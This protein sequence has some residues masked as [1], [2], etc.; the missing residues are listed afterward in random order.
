[1]ARDPARTGGTSLPVRCVALILCVGGACASARTGEVESDDGAVRDAGGSVDAPFSPIDAAIDGA[2]A[3]VGPP[4]CDEPVGETCAGIDG[5]V[6]VR[7]AVPGELS[8]Y[9]RLYPHGD[10]Y[11]FTWIEGWLEPVAHVARLDACGAL[12]GPVHDFPDRAITSIASSGEELAI[13]SEH[14]DTSGYPAAVRFERLAL[15]GTPIVGSAITLDVRGGRPSVAW[16][17]VA[18]QWGMSWLREPPPPEIAKHVR[19][20]RVD[21][22]GVLVPDSDVAISQLATDTGVGEIVW[23]GDRFA[24]PFTFG[25]QANVVERSSDGAELASHHQVIGGEAVSNIGLALQ[26]DGYG[27][28]VQVH[29]IDSRYEIF[30]ERVDATGFLVDTVRLVGPHFAVAPT[31]AWTGTEHAV[32]WHDGD[33]DIVMA[34][35]DANGAVLGTRPMTCSSVVEWSPDVVWSGAQYVIPYVKRYDNTHIDVHVL[36]VSE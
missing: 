33:S 10:G 20:A 8:W 34:R 23:T 29:T 16:D 6:D 3:P 2:P 12:V 26:P 25:I 5:V 36:F 28:V 27:L 4:R 17:P 21:E 19:M 7:I 18:R 13:V 22:D 24:I 11:L 14:V 9:P 31:N 32:A 1:L 35:L 15:D 30:H